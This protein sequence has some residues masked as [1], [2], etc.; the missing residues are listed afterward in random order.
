VT[1]LGGVIGYMSGRLGAE[2]RT[3]KHKHGSGIPDD[4]EAEWSQ[5]RL[6]P[7]T[8]RRSRN[9]GLAVWPQNRGREGFPVWA[10][11]PAAT[12]GGARG[13][14][15]KV[16]SRRSKVVKGPMAFGRRGRS[17]MLLPFGSSSGSFQPKGIFGRSFVYIRGESWLVLIATLA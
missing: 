2:D 9:T 8:W 6:E 16:A 7:Y 12:D 17:W 5:G 15:A 13:T 1:W 3:V 11:K 14:I 4:R 10:S